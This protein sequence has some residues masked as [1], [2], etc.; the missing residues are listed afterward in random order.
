MAETLQ[1]CPKC[2][3]MFSLSDLDAPPLAPTL[4]SSDVLKTNDPPL[5]SQNPFLRDF[6]S[7]GRARRIVLDAKI[8]L[9]QSSLNQLVKEKEKLDLEIGKHEGAVSPL[10]RMPTE[11]LSYIFTFTL[12]P[13][14]PDAESAP[15]TVSAVCARWREIVISQ[16]RFWTSIRYNVAC[17]DPTKTLMY[18][19]HLHRSKEL[20]LHIEF[21]VVCDELSFD[22]ARI[23]DLMCQRAARWETASFSGPEELT[24]LLRRYI[25]CQLT[26]LQKLT[27]EIYADED[28][29]WSTIDAFH[30]APML[31]TVF[32]NRK[33][34]HCP[35]VTVPR[36]TQL[37]RYGGSST[38][39][40]H[41]DAL[42]DA[43]NLVD[44]T[45]EI[46]GSSTSPRTP[47]SLPRL[48]RLSLSNSKFLEYLKTPALLELYCDFSAVPILS[49]LRHRA[50]KLQKLVM[51][52]CLSAQFGLPGFSGLTSIAEAVPALTGLGLLFLIPTTVLCDFCARAPALEHISCIISPTD[53]DDFE[54][55]TH[56]Q[57]F[58][59]AI[60]SLLQVR[61]LK[62]VTVDPWTE[63]KLA[64][65]ILDRV[66]LLRAQGTGFDFV[67]EEVIWDIVPPQFR[68]S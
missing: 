57:S 9:L 50:C 64:P 51:W 7:H 35:I 22:P 48:L 61:K 56:I 10:R 29:L 52:P 26:H 20:P 40:G 16:P 39:D 30:D 53:L 46:R 59:Q 49:F 47:I 31:Q 43:S 5:E 37:L 14:Q 66:E 6:L 23:L 45:L 18:E 54:T 58:M 4:V 11:V 34:S 65:N 25:K 27:I 55:Q 67:D 12:P 36:W 60:E 24:E 63:L 21:S 41:L 15:W 68:L 32:F 8:T 19:T 38:W 42:R 17:S 13:H 2:M 62:S 33:N 44:C 3:H 1:S 28:D